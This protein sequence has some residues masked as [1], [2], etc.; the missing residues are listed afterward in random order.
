MW[1]RRARDVHG[2]KRAR[3]D[4][5]AAI[6]IHTLLLPAGSQ[7]VAGDLYTRG[8]NDQETR[9]RIDR[10]NLH[11]C[12][13]PGVRKLIRIANRVLTRPECKRNRVPV[14]LLIDRKLDDG[15]SRRP[16]GGY[17]LKF[18]LFRQSEV[19]SAIGAEIR[20]RRLGLVLDL[21]FF[22]DD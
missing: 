3:Q 4:I 6:E 11:R 19:E 20:L 17:L 7:A 2:H 21:I 1:R 15:H 9:T 18:A 5:P 10:R 14:V 13:V 8:R 12:G 22:A 16:R